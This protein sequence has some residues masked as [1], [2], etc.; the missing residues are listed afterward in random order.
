MQRRLLLLCVAL[1]LSACGGTLRSFPLE[2]PMWRDPDRRPFEGTPED[3]FS[4]LAW[5]GADQTIFRPISRFFAVDPAGESIN[6]NAVDEVADS[7]WFH[8]RI[9]HR[10][11][12]PTEVARGSCRTT[13]TAPVE[14]WTVTG[15]KPN[16]ANPGFIIEDARGRNYLVKFDGQKAGPRATTA[17]TVGSK[18]YHAAGYNT[19]CNTI[20]FFDRAKLSID[21]EAT[22]ED[23]RGRTVPLESK[24]LSGIF[25]KAPRMGDGRYRASASLFLPGKPIGPFKYQ[26]VRSDD[27]NDVVAHED[28]RELRGMRVLAAWINHFDSR[29][30]NTLSTW[31]ETTEN[32]GFVRH[33]MLDFGDCFGSI[34]EP[35]MMG[36]RLGHAYYFDANYLARDL[37]TFGAIRRPWDKARYG[38]ARLFGYFDVESFVADKWRPGYPNP[39]F[40]RMSERDATWMARI[41]AEFSDEHVREL[42]KVGRIGDAFIEGELVRILIGRRDKIL[43][44][45]LTSLSPLSHPRVRVKG[46]GAELCLRDL[47]VDS[48]IAQRNKRRYGTGSWVGDSLD[49]TPIGS[50]RWSRSSRICLDLPRVPGASDKSPGY[51]VVD[52]AAARKRG[53]LMYPTRVHLYHLGDAR[54]RVVG[55]QRPASFDEAG[56]SVDRR[57]AD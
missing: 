37:F 13:D 15:A 30:Q 44:R 38:P 25:E 54:Y 43:R 50:G 51:L 18:L 10:A 46:A 42:V 26:G 7:S 20:V 5:D 2:E 40:S 1:L 4:P 48:G 23:A 33:N 52:V 49:P 28:R 6:V 12:T 29:E 56:T 14:P 39:A 9:G 3:Y 24:H 8:N 27:P 22:G 45:Y 53:D 36:R 17:D 11:M 32:R 21:P 47:G 16:G 57:N 55:L 41:I 35:P 34:W 19:P 31:I